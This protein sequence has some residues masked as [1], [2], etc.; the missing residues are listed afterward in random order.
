M[1]NIEARHDSALLRVS[2]DT[3]IADHGRWRV[4]LAAL[5]AAMQ[6][7]PRRQRRHYVPH[8]SNRLRADIGLPPADDPP[9][10]IV[11]MLY[12]KP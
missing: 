5:V 4:A 10:P 3:L 9:T 1:S 12:H 7:Q 6:S 2:V 8:M 11:M